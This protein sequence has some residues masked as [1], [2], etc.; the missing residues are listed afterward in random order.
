MAAAVDAYAA[1]VRQS[2][3]AGL[4]VQV[5]AAQACLGIALL[6]ADRLDEAAAATGDALATYEK[7]GD[8]LGRCHHLATSAA[9]Q[10]ELGEPAAAREL[11]AQARATSSAPHTRPVGWM[12]ICDAFVLASE[13]RQAGTDGREE[14]GA[15]LDEAPTD[16]FSRTMVRRLRERM[17]ADD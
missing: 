11:L 8:R 2:L 5:A 3:E 17:S 12:G 9:I 1:A 6:L 16:A 14:V 15:L 4:E 13:H 7:A 10:A